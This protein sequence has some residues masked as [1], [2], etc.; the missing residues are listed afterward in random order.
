VY[1][2]QAASSELPFSIEYLEYVFEG[3]QEMVLKVAS[4]SGAGTFLMDVRLCSAT[5]V[6]YPLPG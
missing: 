1:T 2:W 3:E 5:R 6:A 4:L